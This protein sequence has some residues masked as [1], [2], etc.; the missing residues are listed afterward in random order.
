MIFKFHNRLSESGWSPLLTVHITADESNRK[1]QS[2]AGDNHE[3]G[4]GADM[5]WVNTKVNLRF[6]SRMTRR[7]C[8]LPNHSCP[9]A[10]PTCNAILFLIPSINKP[11]AV[12][13]CKV[14]FEY[15]T[16]SVVKFRTFQPPHIGSTGDKFYPGIPTLG[17]VRT[18]TFWR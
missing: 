16:Y 2:N 18:G 5:T 3:H 1:V 7:N 10:L 6:G 17:A 11:P 15:H 4:S 13:T 12:N 9:L 14:L 8:Q